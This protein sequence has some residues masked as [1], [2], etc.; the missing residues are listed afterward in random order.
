MMIGRGTAKARAKKMI[1]SSRRLSTSEEWNPPHKIELL[2]QATEG[3]KFSQ[4]HLLAIC[5][6]LT[7]WL[8]QCTNS[9]CKNNSRI[10]SWE[11]KVSILF[12]CNTK[13]N[14]T[15]DLVRGIGN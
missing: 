5:S 10:T 15:S 11:S 8:D 2:F 14:E 3:N 9:W 4:V 7:L 6:P 12:S 1:F 13:W